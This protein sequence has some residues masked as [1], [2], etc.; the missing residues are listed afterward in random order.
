MS[1][2]PDPLAAAVAAVASHDTQIQADVR[3]LIR[4]SLNFGFKVMAAGDPAAKM[5]FT[6]T[7]I[8]TLIKS[9]DKGEDRDEIID[10]MRAQMDQLMLEVRESIT[11]RDSTADPDIPLATT[12]PMDQMPS[13]ANVRPIKR[14]AAVYQKPHPL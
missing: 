5:A 7:M 12:P 13:D 2:T 1:T 10:Q 4:M 11:G 9:L 14:T 6:K 8:P 3:K